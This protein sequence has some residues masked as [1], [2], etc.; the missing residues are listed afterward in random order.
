MESPV[1]ER[2]KP[3]SSLMVRVL[4]GLVLAPLTIALILGGGYYFLAFVGVGLI[5]SLYEW[6]NMA[7]H[8]PNRPYLTMLTG[9]IY[10]VIAA[11]SYSFL[12]FGFEQGAWL[13]L[14][15]MLAVWS[16]DIGAYF[17]GI[18]VGGPKLAPHISPKK[19]W[20]GLGGAVFFCG[21]SLMLLLLLGKYLEPSMNTDIGLKDH[22][23]GSVFLIGC[24]LGL[25]GQ[26]GDLF[27]SIFKRRAKL[28]DT[29]VLIPGHGGL[30]DRIDSLLLVC[31]VFVIILLLWLN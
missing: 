13:A 18:K 16:S 14:S 9:G 28:K 11:A 4:S 8:A 3:L 6:F 17:V 27:V 31:P 10:L 21:L 24:F 1:A 25:A 26:A 29:G 5:I 23:I 19:T 12:R 2:K 30:L 22:H 20:A 15:V 7:R